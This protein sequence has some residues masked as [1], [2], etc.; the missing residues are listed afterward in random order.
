MPATNSVFLWDNIAEGKEE[1]LLDNSFNNQMLVL[2]Y[3][4]FAGV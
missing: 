4:V 2:V 3:L 1:K